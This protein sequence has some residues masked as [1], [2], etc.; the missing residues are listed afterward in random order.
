MKR[1]Y[2]AANIVDAAH[3]ANVLMSHGIEAE[4]RNTTLAGGVGEL[5][6]METWPQVWVA[7]EQEQHAKRILETIAKGAAPKE[8][9]WQCGRCGEW[10]AGQFDE[11][12]K[13]AGADPLEP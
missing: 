2:S 8:P 13:C 1:V 3:W 7:D 6:F 10:I 9:A 12:W 4:L 11:C 5:P